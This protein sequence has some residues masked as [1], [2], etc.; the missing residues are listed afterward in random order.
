LKHWVNLSGMRHVTH[1][2]AD[3]IE[4]IKETL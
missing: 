3:W 2:V 4:R 1:L